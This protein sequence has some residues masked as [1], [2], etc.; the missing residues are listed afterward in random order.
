LIAVPELSVLE[1]ELDRFSGRP[2]SPARG[3]GEIDPWVQPAA[4]GTSSRAAAIRAIARSP[5]EHG[6]MAKPAVSGVLC[7]LRHGLAGAIERRSIRSG[8]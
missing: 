3:M 6:P 2:A 7:G 1:P 8:E 4:G 5:G